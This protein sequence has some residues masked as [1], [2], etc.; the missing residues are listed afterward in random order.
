MHFSSSEAGRYLDALRPLVAGISNCEM[1][2]LPSFTSIWVAR[3]RAGERYR[4][5]R[6]GRSSGG[7]RGA[8]R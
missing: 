1:F 3:E 7:R 5:E 8:N 6:P 4:L 2:V